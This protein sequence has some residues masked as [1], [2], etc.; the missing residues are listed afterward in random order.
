MTFYA[1]MSYVCG[2]FGPSVRRWN[3]DARKNWKLETLFHMRCH[4]H[5]FFLTMERVVGNRWITLAELRPPTLSVPCRSFVILKLAQVSDCNARA[6]T[7]FHRQR[8]NSRWT[9][10]SEG[11]KKKFWKG[12]RGWKRIRESS[13]AR[14][15]EIDYDVWGELMKSCRELVIYEWV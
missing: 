12:A 8:L 10:D 5:R 11:P 7:R 4:H 14:R 13:R 1:C 6:V 15:G 9:G 3:R 2:L